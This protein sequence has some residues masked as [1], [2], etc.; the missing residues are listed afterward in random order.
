MSTQVSANTHY[1]TMEVPS[2]LESLILPPLGI[3]RGT[4][5]S[6]KL[7]FHAEGNTAP[8]ST[9]VNSVKQLKTNVQTMCRTKRRREK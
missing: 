3:E 7:S 8:I 5:S 6:W 1:E 9:H 4:D 2:H